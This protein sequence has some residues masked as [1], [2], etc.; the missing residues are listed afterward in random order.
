MVFLNELWHWKIKHLN[1]KEMS[2]QRG[3]GMA[4]G[5][6]FSSEGYKK[7]VTCIKGKQCHQHF[8]KTWAKNT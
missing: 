6:N 2:M 5:V 3:G 1:K 4:G 7:Y 8:R